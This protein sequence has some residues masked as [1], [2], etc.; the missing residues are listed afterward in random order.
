ME[1]TQIQELLK[2]RYLVIADYPYSPWIVGEILLVDNKKG[3][4]VGESIG[5]VDYAYRIFENEISNFPH[6]F[7][8]LEWWEHR[9][10]EELP[11]YV[12]SL[13]KFG[14]V[15]RADGFTS[16]EQAAK[17]LNLF[18]A[19]EQEYLTYQTSINGK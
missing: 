19:T 15:F 2:P 13:D 6:L 9:K 5:Y 14:E 3:E 18:P 4:L 12:K 17:Y 10:P 7:R 1:Q 8:K 16:L 11:Q